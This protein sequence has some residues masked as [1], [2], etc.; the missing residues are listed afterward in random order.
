MPLLLFL[1]C[2]FTIWFIFS[3]IVSMTIEAVVTNKS[4]L[5]FPLITPLDLYCGSA[6]V[7]WM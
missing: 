3:G 1:L 5:T 2:G 4:L 6:V 7:M